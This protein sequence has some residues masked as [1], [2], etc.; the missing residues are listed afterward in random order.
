VQFKQVC[1][2]RGRGDSPDPCLCIYIRL[3][4]VLH[5][6]LVYLLVWTFDRKVFKNISANSNFKPNPKAKKRFR[7]TK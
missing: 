6:E 1:V 2:W 7:K 4:Y 5:A 3:L